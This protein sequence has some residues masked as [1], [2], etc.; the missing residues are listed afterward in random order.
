MSIF[1]NIKDGWLNY[2]KATRGEGNIS[3]ETEEIALERA[4]VCKSCDNLQESGLFRFVNQLVEN[5]DGSKTH[6]KIRHIVR[7]DSEDAD[8][9][10]VV[11]GF[12]CGL[13][14]CGFPANV[15]APN[16]KCPIDKWKR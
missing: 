9:E 10:D 13:C 16:K 8:K 3:P 15:Y 7:P 5:R 11:R 6:R 1:K 14:G 12:K 4:E 2:L